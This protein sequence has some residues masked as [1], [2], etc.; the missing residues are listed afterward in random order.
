M[1]LSIRAVNAR[2]VHELA[3]RMRWADRIE[4]A[5]ISGG[6][7]VDSITRSVERSARS[8][9]GIVDGRCEVMCGVS[10]PAHDGNGT[11]AA[12]A[13]MLTADISQARRE[14]LRAGHALL[15]QMHSIAPLLY[16]FVST[17]NHSA[18]RFVRAMGFVVSDQVVVMDR[19]QWRAVWRRASAPIAFEVV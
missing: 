5:E 13:W 15:P 9:A 4:C 18:F 16:N 11:T 7:V 3:Q 17:S 10:E 19:L 6:T 12:M 14:V 8:W 1:N 2:D